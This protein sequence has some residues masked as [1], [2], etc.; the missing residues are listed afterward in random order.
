MGTQEIVSRRWQKGPPKEVQVRTLEQGSRWNRT[1]DAEHEKV[2]EKK[3]EQDVEVGQEGTTALK[4]EGP[5]SDQPQAK[6]LKIDKDTR[7]GGIT[8]A[9]RSRKSSNSTRSQ[10]H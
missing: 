6:M 7:K 2:K 4:A 5:A 1:T 3:D 9:A 8:S 10:N